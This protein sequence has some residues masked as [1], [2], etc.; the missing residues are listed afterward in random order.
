MFGA[1]FRKGTCVIWRQHPGDNFVFDH[2]YWESF[3][4]YKLSLDFILLF[5]AWT[6]NHSNISPTQIFSSFM[7][8]IFC[9]IHPANMNA[10][11]NSDIVREFANV[12]LKVDLQYY[13]FKEVFVN[14]QS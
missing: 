14:S 7:L 3:L 13:I 12:T 1:Y 4:I 8:Q 11:I 2:R 10:C 6:G 9:L 5:P